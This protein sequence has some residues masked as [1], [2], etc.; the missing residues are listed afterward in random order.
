MTHVS[1]EEARFD[2]GRVVG[3]TFGLIGRNFL[4]FF[5]LALVFVGGPQFAIQYA[6]SMA[7]SS[8]DPLMVSY[9][10][11]GSLLASLVFTYILQ[12]ALTRASVDDLSGK[13]VQFGAA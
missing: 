13:G 10:G 6:Q 8:G 2:F 4:L 11:F 3:Q 7:Y 9:I 5:L 12:G 1:M